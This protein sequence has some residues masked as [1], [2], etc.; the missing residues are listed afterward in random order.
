MTTTNTARTIL[1]GCL[2]ALMPFAGKGQSNTARSEPL[3]VTVR[4]DKAQYKPGETVRV[5][6]TVTNH[7]THPIVLAKAIHDGSPAGAVG[8]SGV[9]AGQP[10]DWGSGKSSMPF[11]GVMV[12]HK[13]YADHF[14]TLDPGKSLTIYWREFDGRYNIPP[15]KQF[16]TKQEYFDAG[17]APLEP[18]E[19]TITAR[20]EFDRDAAP[21]RSRWR[22]LEFT[23]GS[24][25]IFEHAWTGAIDGKATFRVENP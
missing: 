15:G 4:T 6:V 22:R 14:T 2:L 8:L 16:R 10:I 3:E 18:G 11:A 9:H 13:V 21:F 23:A 1:A 20:Y 24:K 5:E 25:P 7:A 17:H 19:Y 12:Q